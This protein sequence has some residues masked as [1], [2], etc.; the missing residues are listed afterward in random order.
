[1][2]SP[3]VWNETF[4]VGHEELDAEHRQLVDAI[5]DLCAAIEMQLRPRQLRPLLRALRIA[6]E[7]HLRHESAVLS[8]ISAGLESTHYPAPAH[9]RV[10]SAAALTEHMT[11]HKRLL[12]KLETIT[13]GSRARHRSAG[14]ELGEELKNWF[15][16]HAIRC[17]AHLKSLFQA[18]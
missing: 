12:S 14:A 10:M 18:L 4:A 7:D 6:V 3:L 16:E 8:H 13:T 17:D 11:K 9:L 5:N 1:M 2:I 15:L